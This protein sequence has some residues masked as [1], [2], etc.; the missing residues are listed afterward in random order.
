MEKHSPL[1]RLFGLLEAGPCGVV[2]RSMLFRSGCMETS[3]G[4][5]CESAEDPSRGF[6]W[7]A[8]KIPRWDGKSTSGKVELW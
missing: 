5:S 4:N 6:Q 7:R 3:L 1:T 8:E 2:R